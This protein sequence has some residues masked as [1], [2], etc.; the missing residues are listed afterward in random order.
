MAK[1]LVAGAALLALIGVLLWQL[2]AS[3]SQPA[4][5]VAVFDASPAPAVEP[6]PDAGRRA[7]KRAP[8]IDDA[9]PA[10][11]PELVDVTSEVGFRRIGQDIPDRFRAELVSCVDPARHDP[12]AKLKVG[13]KMQIVGGWVYAS[14]VRLIESEIDDPAVIRCILRAVE[15]TRFEMDDMPDFEEESE[16]FIRVRS[17]K[18]YRSQEEQTSDA[19]D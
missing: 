6:P 18:K 14:N 4:A 11:R 19:E 9:A 10:E 2:A 3:P 5:R 17:L 15:S 12:N 8:A 13:Y 7:V 16:L 1:W